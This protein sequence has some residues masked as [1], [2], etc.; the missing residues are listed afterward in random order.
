MKIVKNKTFIYL[1]VCMINNWEEITNQILNQIN[2]SG[3]IDKIEN[4]FFFVLGEL[5]KNNLEKIKK[6]QQL[7]PKYKVKSIRKEVQTYEKITLNYL[8]DDCKNKYENCKILYLHTKGITRVGNKNVEDW[9]KY[10]I[11]FNVNKHNDCINALDKYDTCGVNLHEKPLLHYS[12]NFFWANSEY[13]K[14]L[15]ELDIREHFICQEDYVKYY[16]ASEMWICSKTNNCKTLHN[17]NVNHYH[18]EYK[19]ENYKEKKLI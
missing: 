8:L 3:L 4:L 12:G 16:L 14:K 19:E 5:N 15:E 18:Q 11:Y 9:V 6:I 2:T 7:N 1:H 17:S 10:L 13:I